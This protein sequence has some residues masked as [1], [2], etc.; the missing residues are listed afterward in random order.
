[1]YLW[2]E[3]E[4]FLLDLMESLIKELQ[5][6]TYAQKKLPRLHFGVGDVKVVLPQRQGHWT[7]PY[8]AIIPWPHAALLVQPPAREH[9]VYLIGN[10]LHVYHYCVPVIHLTP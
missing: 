7:S 10:K 9:P 8:K 3:M 5:C 1:M 2:A 6:N 4:F